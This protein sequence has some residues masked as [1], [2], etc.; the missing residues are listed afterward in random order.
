MEESKGYAYPW[1]IFKGSPN[2][3]AWYQLENH[4]LPSA[5]DCDN[6]EHEFQYRELLKTK[7]SY[8]KLKEHAEKMADEIDSIFERHDLTEEYRKDFPEETK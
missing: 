7:K 5:K 1:E 6:I 2:E 4:D 3:W 8:D